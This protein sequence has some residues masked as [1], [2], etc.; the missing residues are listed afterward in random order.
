MAPERLI[1][2]VLA[3]C[4]VIDIVEKN[5]SPLAVLEF[6]KRF[7]S[8]IHVNLSDVREINFFNL[9][10]DSHYG[11]VMSREESCFR[12]SDNALDDTPGPFLKF[13]KGILLP[14]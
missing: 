1:H 2:D 9:A 8:H 11:E 6:Y 7:G 4:Q 10:E 13:D 12:F 3:A 14:G 5:N